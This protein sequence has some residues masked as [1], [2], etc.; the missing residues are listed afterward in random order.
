MSKRHISVASAQPGWFA[1]YRDEDASSG[2]FWSPVA[3]WVIVIDDAGE[4]GVE[5]IDPT[6]EGWI[7]ESASDVHNFI[8]YDY[9]PSRKNPGC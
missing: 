5:G 2:E 6:G 1:V 3:C 9:D 8:R 7:G 4:S